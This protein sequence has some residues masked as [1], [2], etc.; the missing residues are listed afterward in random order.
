[1]GGG[2]LGVGL[3][4]GPFGDNPLEDEQTTK[5]R[6]LDF[7]ATNSEGGALRYKN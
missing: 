7:F 4:R 1:M 3:V 2:L 6:N 5:F